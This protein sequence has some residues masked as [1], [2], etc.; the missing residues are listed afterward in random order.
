MHIAALNALDRPQAS[1]AFAQC[2]GSGVWVDRM[3]SARPFADGTALLAA[4]EEVWWDLSADDWQEAFSA[5]GSEDPSRRAYEEK[6]GHAY[7]VF[8]GNR[9]DDDLSALFRERMEHDRLTELGVA[10]AEQA[11][12]T[13]QAL[14]TVF[15]LE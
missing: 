14:R 5:A 10:A 1:A 2:C 15:D 6:F 9:S 13:N 7:V 11:R 12:I 8:P 3:I 4:A